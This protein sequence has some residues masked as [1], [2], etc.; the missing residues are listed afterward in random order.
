[1]I[2]ARCEKESNKPNSPA[3]A[4]P[5]TSAEASSLA[6]KVVVMHVEQ[7]VVK[8][9]KDAGH[10]QVSKSAMG[11]VGQA[12]EAGEEGNDRVSKK[13]TSEICSLR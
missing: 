2:A 10:T 3:R 4:S 8:V 12:C 13:C 5:G 1:M 9:M 7:V 6:V 11:V